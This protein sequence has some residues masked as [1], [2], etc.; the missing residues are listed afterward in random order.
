MCIK[1][2]VDASAFRH[3]LEPSRNSAGHQLRRWIDRGDGVVV[4][5]PD[6][7]V[8]ADELN[9]YIDVRNLLR[10]YS[11]RGRAVDI[12]GTLIQA[13]LDQIPDRP[14]RRSNDP[15]VL[16]LAEVSRA[17]V[18][19]SCDGNLRQDFADHQVLCNVGQQR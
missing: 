10:D 12:D 3:F 4:Y 19:F 1:T 13:V 6:H 2:I 18:L 7:T 11:Q 17:T 5:S 16:A 14:V 15:H 9:R 8:Y